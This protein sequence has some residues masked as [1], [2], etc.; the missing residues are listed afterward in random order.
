MLGHL[1]EHALSSWQERHQ[2]A[3]P[4]VPAPRAPY[5]SVGLEPVDQ[6]NHAV[7]FESKALCQGPDGGLLAFRKPSD[8]QQQ[9][10]LLRFQTHS[11]CHRVA[12]T[13]EVPDAIAQLRQGAVFRSGD[14]SWHGTSIS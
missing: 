14:F 6:F 7:V 5:V 10:I 4:V 11:V 9:Q 12:F 13:D 2:H 3:S 1:R 8:G